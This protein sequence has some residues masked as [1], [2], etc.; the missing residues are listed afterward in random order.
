MWWQFGGYRRWRGLMTST[1]GALCLP[2]VLPTPELDYPLFSVRAALRRGMSVHSEP[3]PSRETL[4]WLSLMQRQSV[5]LT[6]TAR[7]YLFFLS[8]S[9]SVLAQQLHSYQM[10]RSMVYKAITGVTDV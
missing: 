8:M 10:Q 5:V 4:N 6:A 9:V 7:G 3:R 2:D 1:S